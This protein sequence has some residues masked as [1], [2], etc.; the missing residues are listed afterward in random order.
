MREEKREKGNRPA[1]SGGYC[2]GRQKG[3]GGSGGT[4]EPGRR[5][6]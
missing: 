4:E 3:G 5:V 1:S 2:Q 6:V